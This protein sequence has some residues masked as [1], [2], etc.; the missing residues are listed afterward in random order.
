MPGPDV[1][2]IGGGIIGCAVAYELAKRGRSVLLCERGEIGGEASSAAAG[3]LA[4]QAETKGPGPLFDL[5]L[6]SFALIPD[7]LRELEAASGLRVAWER[8]GLL[9]LALTEAD[10]RPLRNLAAWQQ[11]RGL[12]VERW[13]TSRVREREPG[14]EAPV[15]EGWFFPN[16]IR[17]DNAQFT[18]AYAE[19]ARRRGVVMRT[20]TQVGRVRVEQARV[21]GV[22]TTAG[23][24][25]A[26]TV[27][28]AAGCWAGLDGGL[29]IPVPVEPA[30]GQI[31]VYDAPLPHFR[32]IVQTPRVYA[33][34]HPGRTIVGSTVEYVGY[35]KRTTD[36]GLAAIRRGLRE[37]APGLEQQPIAQTWAGLRP[38]APDDW[39]ILGP[40][41]IEGLWMA[42]GHFRSGI[43]LAPITGRLMAELIVDGRSSGSW[44]SFQWERFARR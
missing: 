34:P 30:R 36:E 2:V 33:V 6:A 25:A 11:Q 23:A 44:T 27:V 3:I 17:L 15:L 10:A 31:I 16:E 7:T 40:T 14:I 19:A 35:D 39:P 21:T 5:W 26:P 37:I 32:T 41:S 24:Y 28:D 8:C 4:P 20:H 38:H 9:Q 42:T 1:I 22:E 13:E 12:P 18:R 43:L 29:P